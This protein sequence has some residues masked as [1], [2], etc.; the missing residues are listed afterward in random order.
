MK[1]RRWIYEKEDFGV[2]INDGNGLI[3]IGRSIGGPQNDYRA[4]GGRD[5][6]GY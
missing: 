6:H 2:G 4:G 3:Y 1:K 5:G